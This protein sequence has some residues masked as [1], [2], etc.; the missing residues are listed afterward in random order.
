[1]L[2]GIEESIQEEQLEKRRPKRRKNK[3]NPYTLT[4]RDGRYYVS[5][6]DGQ[7][8]EREVELT[9]QQYLLFN[10]FE[11][12]DKKEA[13][14]RERHYEQS[15]QTESSLYFRSER[16]DEHMEDDIL[17]S[18]E[19]DKLR[20]AIQTLPKVQRRRVVMYFFE[21]LTYDEIAVREGCTKMPVKRSINLALEKIKK[22]LE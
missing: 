6:K 12:E 11:L 8:I 18:I 14:E 17:D 3:D 9:E 10:E 15:E 22:F 2:Y 21:E 20:E 16:A 13:N 19:K 5:F 1:M 7:R 4:I